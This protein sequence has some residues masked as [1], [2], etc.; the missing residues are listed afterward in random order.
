MRRE[1][2]RGGSDRLE[3]PRAGAT[4]AK[5]GQSLEVLKSRAKAL[6]RLERHA[7]AVA[8]L[9]RA[10]ELKPDDPRIQTL[11]SVERARVSEKP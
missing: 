5:V 10:R 3:D 7:E 2:V 1:R 8:A 11:L 6:S 9:E 4:A